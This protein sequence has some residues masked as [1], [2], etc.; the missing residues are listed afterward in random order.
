[1]AVTTITDLT[2]KNRHI[3]T[4]RLLTMVGQRVDGWRME[5][6]YE[7]PYIWEGLFENPE[8]AHQPVRDMFISAKNVGL[9]NDVS[10]RQGRGYTLAVS[11]GGRRYYPILEAGLPEEVKRREQHD[12]ED[13]VD[14]YEREHTSERETA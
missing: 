2:I 3:I 11:A 1:M 12:L 9:M 14:I 10:M 6:I 8:D 5:S 7:D 13:I 4:F